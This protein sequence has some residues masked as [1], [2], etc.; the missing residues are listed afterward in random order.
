MKCLLVLDNAPAHPPSLHEGIA[1]QYSFIRIPYLPLNT[2]PLLQPMDQQ[3]ISKFK[4]L[5]TKYLFKRCFEI[6]E[7]TN[8]TLRQFWKEHFDVVICL[9]MI[10]Q[11]WQEILRPTLNSAWK[12]L[13]HDA[14][15]ARDLEGFHADKIED[16]SENVDDPE[17]VAQAEVAEIITLGKSMDLE[18]DEADINELI[19]EHQEELTTNDLKELE[20]MRGN[21]IQEECSWGEEDEPLT[22]A[23]IKEGLDGYFKMVAPVEKTHPE[24]MLTGRALEY[25]N[26]VCPSYFRKVL[27]CRQKQASLDAYFSKRPE[28]DQAPAKKW[29]ESGSDEENT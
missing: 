5:Y 28:A 8:L 23:K 20:A 24:K 22:T 1:A 2:T 16:Y 7:S 11:A 4:K 9:K 25:C 21:I 26:E 18:V 13:W 14:V 15:S 6:I 27:R 10:D 29:K 3:G 19:Q 17:P 12:K